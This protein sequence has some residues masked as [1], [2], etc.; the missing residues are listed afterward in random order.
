MT[1][2]AAPEFTR[3]AGHA[4]RFGWGARGLAAVG[5]GAAAIVI[6]DVLSFATATDVAVSRGIE[7]VPCRWRDERAGEIAAGLTKQLLAYAGK[8]SLS[9]EE[10]DVSL[11][12]EE[13]AR[14]LQSGVGSHVRLEIEAGSGPARVLKLHVWH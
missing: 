13:M 1:G 12:V 3:Q 9:V 5:P 14:L 7:V 4:V 6:V 2:F 8:T 10:I 11:L